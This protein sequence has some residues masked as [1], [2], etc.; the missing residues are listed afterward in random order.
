MYKTIRVPI[1]Y[2]SSF[3]ESFEKA[4]KSYDITYKHAIGWY[5]D[6]AEY[7]K[8]KMLSGQ[9]ID[10]GRDFDFSKYLEER[11]TLKENADYMIDKSVDIEKIPKQVYDKLPD[12]YFGYKMRTLF[13]KT[14]PS[15]LTKNYSLV[16]SA[17]ISV[18]CTAFSKFLISNIKKHNSRKSLAK[19][20]RRPRC[21]HPMSLFKN[22]H[23]VSSQFSPKITKNG[24]LYL[25]GLGEIDVGCSLTEHDMRS[26]TIVRRN[27]HLSLFISVKV[28]D[29]PRKLEG[30]IVGVD[31]GVKCALA[32]AMQIDG[33]T[34]TCRLYA[35]KGSRRY[36][37]DDIAILYSKRS[38][39]KRNSRAYQLLTKKI[40]AKLKKILNKSKE[41]ETKT[42]N[43][44]AGLGWKIVVE[45]MDLTK[46]N[47]K[48]YNVTG[49]TDLHREVS[50]ARMGFMRSAI[51]WESEKAGSCYDPEPAYYTSRQCCQCRKIDSM[52]RITQ[53]EYVCT[54]CGFTYHADE[55]A[56]V[57][58]VINGGGA[59][60][61][62]VVKQKDVSCLV[63][64]SKKK[65][66]M[67]GRPM[68]AEITRDVSDFS[69]NTRQLHNTRKHCNVNV[70]K[71]HT[72]KT[73]DGKNGCD[74]CI[75][76]CCI[77]QNMFFKNN[78]SRTTVYGLC[79]CNTCYTGEITLQNLI[80]QFLKLHALPR[81]RHLSV[82]LR[83]SAQF[84]V[85][86]HAEQIPVPCLQ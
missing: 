60:G 45:D 36:E 77:C 61:M 41:F 8:E 55:Q 22:Q 68:I 13:R 14:L 16:Q 39:K 1:W 56:A 19:D 26:F 81:R 51:K 18:A 57:N 53:S 58:H 27:G 48:K 31:L 67:N 9:D 73:T 10:G 4:Q 17:A 70:N 23:T 74:L 47:K 20:G 65:P 42:A 86:Y 72:R 25:S 30:P 80:M 35:P 43:T 54:G 28:P 79:M 40:R 75:D 32:I 64:I 82:P 2:N 69:R 15:E 21:R 50:Y 84:Q 33:V 85:S 12:K 11:K 6:V 49:S 52:S 63:R 5:C 24:K 76:D 66:S 37:N 38:K 34:Y 29:P 46:M 83:L 44:I 78:L 7:L 59:A 3:E 62:A 71:H